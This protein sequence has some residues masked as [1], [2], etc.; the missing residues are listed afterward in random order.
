MF[1]ILK[2]IK[3]Y[4]ALV[5]IA[6]CSTAIIGFERAD[7]KNV[8]VACVTDG[9]LNLGLVGS[10]KF[11]LSLKDYSIK[12]YPYIALFGQGIVP[13]VLSKKLPM[14]D[15]RLARINGALQQ[16]I[17]KLL[18]DMQRDQNIN[19][20]DHKI[21]AHTIEQKLYSES[22]ALMVDALQQ[23]AI[24]ESLDGNSEK[25]VSF[26]RQLIARYLSSVTSSYRCSLDETIKKLQKDL[27][28]EKKKNSN[29]IKELEYKLRISK[30]EADGKALAI[31]N[32][33]SCIEWNI[34]YTQNEI[35][36]MKHEHA[37]EA[38]FAQLS[39]SLAK[40]KTDMLK[41]FQVLNNALA[42]LSMNQTDRK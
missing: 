25:F 4:A 33:N 21:I 11:T 15:T 34:K 23:A 19:E 41:K 17:K 30:L 13:H 38:K 6:F 22:F 28:Q 27:D 32:E 7:K 10:K 2:K 36:L 35:K 12:D 20:R 26:V 29:S 9:Y 31:Q 42:A 1:A 3:L 8:L 37:L 40:H 16:E 24:V 18:E 14:H 39:V 5:L